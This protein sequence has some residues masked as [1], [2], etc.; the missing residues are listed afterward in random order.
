MADQAICT[1]GLRKA[2]PK[3]KIYQKA[4]QLSVIWF[5]STKRYVKDFLP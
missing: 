1:P 4:F 2:F 3:I 5:R